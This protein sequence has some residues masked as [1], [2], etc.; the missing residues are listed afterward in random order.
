MTNDDI[1]TIAQKAAYAL[2]ATVKLR[3]HGLG[4]Q[5]QAREC[6]EYWRREGELN[7]CVGYD[8]RALDKLGPDGTESYT[9]ELTDKQL[10]EAAKSAPK[11]WSVPAK[12]L[13]DDD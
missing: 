5:D 4:F 1:P 8:A 10:R 9:Y 3:Y 11:W 2:G 13:P 7:I 6:V 12:L